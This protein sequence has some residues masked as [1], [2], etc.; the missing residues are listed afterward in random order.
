MTALD[1]ALDP[2]PHCE[3]CRAP[4]LAWQ[5]RPRCVLWRCP[6]CGH[7][8]RDLDLA[9]ADARSVEYGGD[10]S[11]DRFRRWATRRRVLASTPLRGS[12]LDVGCGDGALAGDLAADFSAVVGVDVH[13]PDEP[14]GQPRFVRSTFEDAELAAES[15]DAVT[16][17]HVVEHVADLHQTLARIHHLLK[18]GGTVYLITPNASSAALRIFREDWWMLEDPTHRR[19]L[20]PQSAHRA[21]I[22]SG[23]SDVHV[24]P[25]I[26]DSLMVEGASAARALTRASHPAGVLSSTAL[27]W[28]AVA[29]TPAT[30]VLRT[31]RP[32]W[33]DSLEIVARRPR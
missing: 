4:Y 22:D 14:Q 2:S 1:R 8:E 6:R 16:A 17:I 13:A 15:F 21:L 30:L 3:V 5:I 32:G 26:T 18:P 29:T 20:S 9:R 10:P 24:T 28:A 27:R 31:V 23:F 33:R 11:A 7:I 19:F 12:L 25:L